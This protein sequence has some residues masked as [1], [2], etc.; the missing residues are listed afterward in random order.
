MARERLLALLADG[1][2]HSRSEVEEVGV[3]YPDAWIRVLRNSGYEV[4]ATEEGFR[5]LRHAE[6]PEPEA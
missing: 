5:L 4:D 1:D 2:W 3:H 6:S